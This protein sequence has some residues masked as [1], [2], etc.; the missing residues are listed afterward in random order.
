MESRVPPRYIPFDVSKI[1]LL[2]FEL[3]LLPFLYPL[4]NSPKRELAPSAAE[5]VSSIHELPTRGLL[6]NS[7]HKKSRGC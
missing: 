3:D 1:D 6:G 5:R 4:A 2:P 7:K